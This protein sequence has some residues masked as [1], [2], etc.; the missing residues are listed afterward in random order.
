MNADVL[1]IGSGM[2][3]LQLAKRLSCDLHV[4]ILTK[5]TIHHSNSYLAQGGIAAAI[6]PKDHAEYHALDT[7]EA[8]R[9][10]NNP[11]VVAEIT[12]CASALINELATGGCS[13]DCNPNGEFLLGMEGA[14]SKARIVH[15][16]GDATGKTVVE[17]LSGHLPGNITIVEDFF[18]D[19]L[20]LNEK[21]ECI[22]A[23]GLNNQNEQEAYFSTY[24]VIA[25]GGC[26]QTYEYTSSAKTVTG[27]GL[28]LAYLAGAKLSDME[29][30]QFHPTLLS[31]AGKTVGL[32]SEAVRGEGAVLVTREGKRI[33]ETVH[34][35]KDLAPRHIVSQTIYS[36]LQRGEAV[37]LDISP[38]KEFEKKFP[39]I[40][41][42]CRQ[43][44]ID[45]ADNKLPV[46][47]G[48]H[49]LMGGISAELDGQTSV[50]CL[51]AIGE[52]ACTGL[53]GANRLASNSLL[54]GLYMGTKLASKIN[55]KKTVYRSFAAKETSFQARPIAL[56]NAEELQKR[57]MEDV[58]IVRTRAGLTRNLQWLESF[59]IKDYRFIQ[60]G[61]YSKQE[62]ERAF[63]L[64]V[65]WLIT[66]AALERTESRG[67]HF[68]ED[69]PFEQN[70]WQQRSIIQ[71]LERKEQNEQAET[72]KT[73]GVFFY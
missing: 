46:A 26:G 13:F 51:Y 61:N 49:F 22:G 45:L 35:Y 10:H 67:G 19:E 66:N 37:Y 59:G 7:L 25:T 50:K 33:M 68:R 40:T 24:T 23:K 27:D 36:Y 41:K 2:A 3:G 56:P 9:F 53:H 62:K 69:Y 30:M 73:T 42:M 65:S 14:H 28:A 63:M 16:G 57:M 1:I 5:S 11:H 12:S 60:K 34:P 20:L 8:G 44:G 39:S 21:G 48:S 55:R 17:F 47:P 71:Q 6:S 4:I 58:G 72:E 29:F 15:G 64:L 52:A 31:V 54:E 43:H 70:E 18:V 32:V 38:V